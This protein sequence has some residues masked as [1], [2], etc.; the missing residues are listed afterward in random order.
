MEQKDLGVWITS[1]SL[2]Y[3]KIASKYWEEFKNRSP[4]RVIVDS[5]KYASYTY[6]AIVDSTIALSMSLLIA[7]KMHHILNMLLSL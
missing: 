7:L 3:Q 1:S 4:N 2:H 6:H 5:T